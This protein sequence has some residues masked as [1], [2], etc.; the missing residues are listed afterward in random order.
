MVMLMQQLYRYI[1]SGMFNAFCGLQ[2]EPLESLLSRCDQLDLRFADWDRDLGAGSFW[3]LTAIVAL[4]KLINPAVC[5]EIGTG[6]GR[7][8]LHLA[9]NTRPDTQI[10]TLDVS[11]SDETGCMFRGKTEASKITS[12]TGDSRT[13]DYSQWKHEVDLVYVD[14]SHDY[15][16]V[17][18]DSAVGFEL[19]A[20][21]G[22]IIWDD[23]IPS[24]PGVARA[25]RE[26][27][28]AGLLR[29]V[30]GTKLVCYFEPA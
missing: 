8:T 4:T 25:L 2:A 29:R 10:H 28:R 9:L 6:Q 30:V 19:V 22:C 18:L 13:F 15:E 5:F 11:N 16:A 23:F 1:R 3:D 27:P 26:S 20:K 21:G 14:G 12:W 7:T 17:R 24:W